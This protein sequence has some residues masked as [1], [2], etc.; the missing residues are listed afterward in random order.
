M[1]FDKINT[2]QSDGT[3]SILGADNIIKALEQLPRNLNNKVLYHANLSI[4]QTV[5]RDPLRAALPYGKYSKRGIGLRKAKGTKTGV[6]A[7]VTST[8]FWLRFLEKGT[9][10]RTTRSNKRYGRT[11]INRG[12]ISPQPFII[13]FINSKDQELFNETAELY[14]LYITESLKKNL[15]KT[16][17]KLSK[18]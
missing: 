1:S 10:P 18:L 12:R 16:N 6:Y 2:N 5:I 15:D 13:P 11:K 3:G 8:A 17:T 14:D 7:G 4:V 9:K